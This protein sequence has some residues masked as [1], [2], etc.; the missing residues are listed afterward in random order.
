M[1]STIKGW[2]SLMAK[3]SQLSGSQ[4]EAAAK[5]SAYQCALATSGAAKQ[6]AESDSGELR[7]SI[8][9]SIVVENGVAIGLSF[10]NSDHAAFV[11]FG[12]GVP[13]MESGGNGSDV[14]V[15]YSLGPYKVKRGNF[16]SGQ[17]VE[18]WEDYWVYYDEVKQQFYAT[19]GQPA[20]PFMFPA[21]QA[22]KE[23]AGEIQAKALRSFLKSLGV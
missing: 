10:T 6:L 21:A 8:Q 20:K 16:R 15:S 14:K 9:T 18:T 22:V 2:D 12:T 7:A 19:R 11:E 17:T 23:Q 1:S 5:D 3:V 4:I 13:G